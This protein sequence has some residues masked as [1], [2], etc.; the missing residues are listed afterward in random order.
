MF[1]FTIVS[2][3]ALECFGVCVGVCIYLRACVWIL[4]S[5]PFSR[6]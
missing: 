4:I 6:L 5:L 1:P 3:T 2:G